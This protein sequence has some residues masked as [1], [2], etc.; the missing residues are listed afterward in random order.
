MKVVKL[1]RETC[2]CGWK[3]PCE[4]AVVFE[5]FVAPISFKV[6]FKCP[7]CGRGLEKEAKT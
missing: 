7:E 6:Q 5:C 1:V 2:P 4:L 3:P